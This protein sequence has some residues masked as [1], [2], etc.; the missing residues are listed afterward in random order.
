MRLAREDN[1]AIY[2]GKTH[3][4]LAGEDGTAIYSGKTHIR[5]AG[6]DSTA[7]DSGKTLWMLFSLLYRWVSLNTL[8]RE[9]LGRQPYAY[10]CFM[11]CGSEQI[12]SNCVYF[13]PNTSSIP[14]MNN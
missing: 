5:L 13:Q 2:S 11:R 12:L 4:R 8:P 6:E 1:T 14:S 10:C 3:T 7:I 9:M